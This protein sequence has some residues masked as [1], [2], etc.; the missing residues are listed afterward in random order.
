M[1]E[2]KKS[3]FTIEE[4][5]VS[6]SYPKLVEVPKK[7]TTIYEN[8]QFTID[9]LNVIRERWGGPIIVTSGYRNE[10]LNRAVGGSPTS[11]HRLGLAADIHP[12][13][14]NILDLAKT[15]INSG[16]DYDQV[17]LEYVTRDKDGYITDCKW[18]HVGFGRQSNR[19]QILAYNGQQYKPVKITTETRFRA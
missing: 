9:R 2:E 12:K 7:G 15:I 13:S 3:Y 18:I 19:K 5:C 8:I 6:G 16:V 11:F 14:G 4:M 10:K 1:P 17:I